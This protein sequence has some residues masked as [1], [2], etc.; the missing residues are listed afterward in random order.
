MPCG[1]LSKTLVTTFEYPRPSDARPFFKPRQTRGSHATRASRRDWRIFFKVSCAPAARRLA[2][3]ARAGRQ[4][5]Y[6][7]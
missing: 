3:R 4:G 2:Q 7:Y 1:R 6:L 5:A